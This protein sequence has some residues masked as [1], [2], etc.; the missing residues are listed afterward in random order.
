MYTDFTTEYGS[1][2]MIQQ[3]GKDL[4]KFMILLWHEIFLKKEVADSPWQ[5]RYLLTT[6]TLKDYRKMQSNLKMSR[7]LQS[8]NY[9]NPNMNMKKKMF[10]STVKPFNHFLL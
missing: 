1:F 9:Q 7:I 2:F 4:L 6:F 8:M 5:E 10:F 3:P